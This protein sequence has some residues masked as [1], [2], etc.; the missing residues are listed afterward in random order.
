[1]NTAKEIIAK[2]L[3]ENKIE[4][5]DAIVLL[6]TMFNNNHYYPIYPTYPTYPQYDFNTPVTVHEYTTSA[7]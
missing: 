3:K 2:L 7:N 5:E 6:E 1:M 4:P